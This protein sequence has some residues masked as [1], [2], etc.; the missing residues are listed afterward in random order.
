MKRKSLI[1]A[2]MLVLTA[3]QAS[4]QA[5]VY[6][7]ESQSGNMQYFT[8][9]S[10]QQFVGDCIPYFHDGTYY[11]YWLLDEGHHA[12]LGGLGG[13]Q[14]CVS[15]TKDLVNWEHHPIAIGIDE[16]WEK[17][18]CT[19][20][21]TCRD[22]QFYAFYA[23]RRLEDGHTREQLSYAV[24]PDALH[25]RKQQPNPFYTSAPG[26][27]QTHFRDPKVT[28]DEEGIFHLFVSSEQTGVEG[29]RGCLVHMTSAD[30]RNW[31]VLPPVLDKL[32]AVPE[33]PDY[34]FWNGW[35]YLVF[36]QNLNTI[37][38]KSRNPYGPWEYPYS[39]AL[40]EDW[41]N[42]AKTAAF[43][44]GRRIAAGWIPSRSNGHDNGGQVFGGC[45]VLREVY[46]LDNGDLATSFPAELTPK[47]SKCRFTTGT[48]ENARHKRGSVEVSDGRAQFMGIPHNAKIT[49]DIE[50]EA[51]C[52]EFGFRLRSNDTGTTGYQ[53]SMKPEE[54]TVALAH[55]AHMD[56]VDGLGGKISLTVILT[57]EVIDVDINHQR[58]IVNRLP[59][60]TG[61]NLWAYAK[62][63]KIK[64]SRMKIEQLAE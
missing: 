39:Q 10:K 33:C 22:G 49:M 17:S 61:S 56:K 47:G 26:Y 42:V 28:V 11:L 52:S 58:C 51:G 54:G 24:S 5:V 21:V 35:Y 18:I 50:P 12:S 44:G 60:Q 4:A 32:G 38:V 14:W 8:P 19:G 48:L 6:D 36:G 34:F 57:D 7:A 16:D 23:T 55:D 15:T 27:S 62:G 40:K 43:P 45:S 20:S 64:V 25:F 29:P 37:Y 3:P 1:A 31:D 41:V 30:L 59:D 2:L 63:G 9:K 53:L 46:Q 13:H